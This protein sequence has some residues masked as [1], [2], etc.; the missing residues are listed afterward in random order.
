MQLVLPLIAILFVT[1]AGPVQ[2]AC[3]IGVPTP[4]LLRLSTDGKTLS[5]SQSG[6]VASIIVISDITL[7]LGGTDITLSNLRLDTQPAGFTEPITL[8]AS[9]SANWLLGSSSGSLTPTATFTVPA[10]T[11][12]VVTVTLN[13]SVTSNTGFRQGAYATKTSIQCS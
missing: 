4:G 11:G 10:V 6:G 8:A 3:T 5:S 9:Y 13:N 1:F 7:Q 12:L 2:A